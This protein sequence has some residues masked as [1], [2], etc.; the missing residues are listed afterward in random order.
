MLGAFPF[1]A[2]TEVSQPLQP[3]DRFLL[4][5][6]GILEAGND[7]GE[8]YGGDRLA[9]LLLSTA[10]MDENEAA[11]RIVHQVQSWAASQEDD[12]TVLICDYKCASVK[13]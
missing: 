6:D 3:G 8:E 7:D 1:A 12:L 4:Y 9:K 10:G 11:D 5:T 13:H 2:Y